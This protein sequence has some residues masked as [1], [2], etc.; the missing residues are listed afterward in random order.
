MNALFR[1]EQC[2]EPCGWPGQQA[3]TQACDYA[4]L[5]LYNVSVGTPAKPLTANELAGA[6]AVEFQHA[7]LAL[8]KSGIAIAVTPLIR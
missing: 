4:D 6:P 1:K 2:Y 3:Q 5:T 7:G 8:K